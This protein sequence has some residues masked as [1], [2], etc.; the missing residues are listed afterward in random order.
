MPVQ[1]T[2]QNIRDIAKNLREITGREIKHTQIIGAIAAA[3]GRQPNAL[4]HELKN[5][6]AIPPELQRSG[7]ASDLF[8]RNRVTKTDVEAWALRR[9]FTEIGRNIFS[10]PW[11]DAEI[12]LKVGAKDVEVKRLQGDHAIKVFDNSISALYLDQ[13]D[14]LHGL[15]LFARYYSYYRESGEW[16]VWFSDEVKSNLREAEQAT[17]LRKAKASSSFKP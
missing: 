8:E 6:V 2:H 1:L 17:E 4:M 12:W 15:D 14:M 9:G 13:F 11:G 5:E 7:T 3:L 10:A 16:P